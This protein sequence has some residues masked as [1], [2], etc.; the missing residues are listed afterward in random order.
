D[1]AAAVAEAEAVLMPLAPL[2]KSYTIH[3]VGHAHIDM[4]WQWPWEETVAAAADTFRTALRLMDEFPGFTLLQSQAALY[5]AIDRYHPRLLDAIRERV[6]AGTWEVVASHWVEG[7][8]NLASGESLVRQLLTAR[9]FCRDRLGLAPQDVP[10]DWV[11]DCF[12]HAATLPAIDAA[13]GAR[14][15]YCWRTGRTDRP[16]LFRWRSP[17]GAEVLVNRETVSYCNV[18]HPDSWKQALAIEQ[19]CGVRGWLLVYGVGDHGG[20]PTRRH[21]RRILDQD[22]WP[23][24]PRWRF[25]TARSWFETI[26]GVRDRLPVIADELNTEYTGCMTSQASVKRNNR[27]GEV[28]CAE[29]DAAG[30]LGLAVAGV[31]P[32]RD[33]TVGAWQDVCF[34]QFHDILPGSGVRATREYSGGQQQRILAATGAATTESLRA[35]ADR[36]DLAW[37]GAAATGTVPAAEP[38]CLGGGSGWGAGSLYAGNPCDGW[39]AGAVWFNPLALPRDEVATLR[40]WEGEGWQA[41]GPERRFRLRLE[42]GR[43]LPAQRLGQGAYW[44]HRYVDLAVPVAVGSAGWTSAAVEE[45]DGPTPPRPAVAIREEEGGRNHPPLVNLPSGRLALENGLLTVEFDRLTGTVRSLRTGDGREFAAGAGFAALRATVERPYP[46]SA[47]ITGDD[48]RIEAPVCEGL[49]V[50]HSG[51]L[52]AAVQAKL[53]WRDSTMT[54]T[55]TLTA[56]SPRLAV[57]VEARWLERGGPQTGIP[58]LSIRFPSTLAGAAPRYEIP[59]GSIT[60][61]L[62]PGRIVPSQRFA[63]LAAGGAALTVANDGAYGHACDDG[64]LAVD[65]VRSS[66]DPDPLPDCG[67]HRWAFTV[68]PWTGEPA[69]AAQI[70]EGLLLNHPLRPT[71]CAAHGGDL[72][73]AAGD[74]IACE[75]AALRIVQVKPAEDGDGLIVRL[76]ETAGTSATPRL[77]WR[78]AEI[79]AAPTDL[80]ERPLPGVAAIAA[81]GIASLRIRPG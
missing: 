54:V 33:L 16:P 47:W 59:F 50:V 14:Y 79:A 23:V 73:A 75:P 45:G 29:A 9:T 1:L 68:R 32:R 69:V 35:I 12:G 78:G 71:L 37:V 57:A 24:F 21:I 64:C 3:C 56:G 63:T 28:A 5:A 17:D 15:Y 65:L 55:Y 67:D 72:P 76:Q 74:I 46:M 30:A 11:P 81:H 58:R 4:N 61:D 70:D 48:M 36:I 49:D 60:R 51:P 25:A 26:D 40:V 53:R 31:A 19:A 52:Q 42:D 13:A 2:A 39:P 10:I 43:L 34:G 77:R 22:S 62:Q 66:Y 80:L 7:D 6:R 44:G 27:R 18:P 20:G 38:H 41:D 8:R